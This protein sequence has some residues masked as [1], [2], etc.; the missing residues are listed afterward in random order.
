MNAGKKGAPNVRRKLTPAPP[1]LVAAPHNSPTPYLLLLLLLFQTLCLA[2][3]LGRALHLGP[4]APCISSP[5]C[6]VASALRL[7][8]VLF[9]LL[10]MREPNSLHTFSLCISLRPKLVLRCHRQPTSNNIGPV[11]PSLPLLLRPISSPHTTDPLPS[12]HPAPAI[13]PS[14]QW[15]PLGPLQARD[16]RTHR[17]RGLYGVVSGRGGRVGG[18]EFEWRV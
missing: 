14:P 18:E 2:L 12:G 13:L 17:L 15:L 16:R 9:V 11:C 3:P 4:W 6:S 7:T 1:L 10:F 8:L 5:A